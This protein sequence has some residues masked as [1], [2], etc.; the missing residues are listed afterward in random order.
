MFVLDG[1]KALNK[2]VKDTFGDYATIQRCQ[3]HKKRNVLSHLP[4]S[5]QANVARKMSLAYNEFAFKSADAQL[6]TLAHRLEKRY[7]KATSSLLEDLDETLA[8]YRLKVPG[9]LRETLCSTNPIESANASCVGVLR[10]VSH[11]QNGRM[12]LRHAAAGFWEAEKGFRR[13]RGFR[14]LPELL[15][16]LQA[17]TTDRAFV[18]LTST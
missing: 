2:A 15:T 8:V 17:L 12:T 13:I 10:R 5:E 6:R 11:F 7:P 3:V 9:L 16:A 4:Q 1:A 14:E 18:T